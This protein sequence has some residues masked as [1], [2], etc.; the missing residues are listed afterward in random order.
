MKEYQENNRSV[1]D[2]LIIKRLTQHSM[3][4]QAS[5]IFKN[6]KHLE[7][8]THDNEFEVGE[9]KKIHLP[10]L[11]SLKFDYSR[12]I[13]CF[14]ALKSLTQIQITNWEDDAGSTFED[15]FD[16]SKIVVLEVKFIKNAE[17]ILSL[18]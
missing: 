8:Y 5:N 13:S 10:Y 16:P 7:V 9:Y 17:K 11:Q 14:T 1:T 18:F 12:Y 3:L 4:L 15:I 2:G 6:I